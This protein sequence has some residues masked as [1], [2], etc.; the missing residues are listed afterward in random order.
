MNWYVVVF[1]LLIAVH[2]CCCHE[3]SPDGRQKRSVAIPAYH[4]KLSVLMPGKARRKRYATQCPF[5][6]TR[7]DSWSGSVCCP[8]LNAVCCSDGIH[9]CPEGHRCVESASYVVQCAKYLD[10]TA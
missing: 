7:C 4:P 3:E 1:T 9:C 8:G 10:T 2:G 6:T 5:D